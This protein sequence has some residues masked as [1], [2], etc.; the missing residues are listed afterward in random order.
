[1]SDSKKFFELVTSD[2]AVQAELE[3]ASFE[4]LKALVAEKGLNNEAQKA[5]ADAAAKVADAHGFTLGR[6]D[7]IFP[8]DMKTVAGG[9]SWWE[10]YKRLLESLGA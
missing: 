9:E 10:I 6:V 2:K 1:M 3:K 4:G 7:E 5:L 8:E